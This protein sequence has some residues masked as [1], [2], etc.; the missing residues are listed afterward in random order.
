[1]GTTRDY[2]RYIKALLSP[3]L[4]AITIGGIDLTYRVVLSSLID[5]TAVSSL[6]FPITRVYSLYGGFPKL[7]VPFLG[8][9][10]IRIIVFWFPYWGP[11]ILGNY[12]I[13]LIEFLGPL[14]IEPRPHLDNTACTTLLT[15]WSRSTGGWQHALAAS[16]HIYLILLGMENQT[17]DEAEAGGVQGWHRRR[18]KSWRCT[19]RSTG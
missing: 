6:Q 16:R 2:C 1:M 8:A 9:P 5:R 14:F 3:C 15:A 17:E 10:I 19:V 7:G 4:G 13:A 18:N 12:H 11:S